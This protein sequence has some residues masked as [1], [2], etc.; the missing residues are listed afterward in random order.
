MAQH[1]PGPDYFD[2]PLKVTVLGG[3]LVLIGPDSVAVVI[4]IDAAEKSARILAEAVERAKRG[5]AD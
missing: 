5:E 2:E 4:T 1:A 3:G